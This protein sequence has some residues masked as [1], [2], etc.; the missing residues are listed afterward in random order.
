MV[1]AAPSLSLESPSEC[2][3]RLTAA[4]AVCTQSLANM[5]DFQLTALDRPENLHEE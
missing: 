3:S 4:I 1:T 5:V 2:K